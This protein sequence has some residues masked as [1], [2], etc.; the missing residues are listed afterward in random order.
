M[1][2]ETKNVLLR[3]RAALESHAEKDLDH[4]RTTFPGSPKR[5]RMEQQ[6]IGL[7]RARKIVDDEIFKHV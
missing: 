1:N 6:A 7:Q 4:A 5:L 3:I 2:P